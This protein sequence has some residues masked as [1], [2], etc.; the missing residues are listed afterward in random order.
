MIPRTLVPTDVRPV[1][2]DAAKKPA[3]R[4]TTYMDDR[5]VV[6]SDL[7][8]APPLDGKTTI[9][10]HFPLDVLVNRT[11]VPRG[12]AAK[13]LENIRPMSEYAPIAILDSRVVVPAFVAPP[14]AAEIEKFDQPP[15]MTAALRE[16]VEPDVFNTGDANLLMEPEDKR[17]PKADMIV[18]AASVVVHIGLIIF[19][20]SIPKIFP[21]HVPTRE[22]IEMARQQLSFVYLPPDVDAV[23]KR[24]PGPAG[25]KV[26][27]DSGTLN[28]VAPPR[29]EAHAI[30][31]PPVNPER[32]PSD[33]PSAPTP[34]VN[35]NPQPSQPATPAPSQVEPI[36]PPA[37]PT[38]G[39]LNLQLPSSSPGKA[40]QDQLQDA[41]NRSGGRSYGTSGTMPQQGPGRGRGGG[42]G[43]GPSFGNGVTILTPTE[44]VNFDSYMNRLIATIRRNW[45]AVMPESAMMGDRGIV[46][47]TFQINPDGSVP[48][49]DPMLE[50][51][52]GKEPLDMAAMSAIH[53]SSPFEPLP[54]QFHGPYIR[55]RIIFLYNLPLDYAK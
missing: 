12:M 27:I 8:D 55:L 23:S 1:S 46:N 50:R 24:P 33:L 41:V 28:K 16:I 9:P 53:A 49:P 19:L 45:Y 25:P 18:R 42:G 34:R 14:E 21:Y 30:E 40:I 4:L 47:I 39:R 22:E 44:G 29:P 51:T 54:S 52:S 2:A 26:R 15:E 10:S 5:T 35:T 37:Q 48:A 13:P 31:A 20:I 36:R 43:G 6:P 17:N 11:L 38:P 32:A 7:S 3:R